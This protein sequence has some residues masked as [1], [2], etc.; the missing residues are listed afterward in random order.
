[1]LGVIH[2]SRMA[3]QVGRSDCELLATK[4]TILKSLRTGESWDAYDLES[5]LP[6]KEVFEENT[7]FGFLLRHYWIPA[8]NLTFRQSMVRITSA[9]ESTRSELLIERQMARCRSNE[10]TWREKVFA[11]LSPRTGASIWEST[12][13][14]ETFCSYDCYDQTYVE[15]EPIRFALPSNE[16]EKLMARQEAIARLPFL[17]PPGPVP[18]GFGWYSKAGTSHMNFCLESKEVVGETSVLAIKREGRVVVQLSLDGQIDYSTKSTQEEFSTAIV[19]RKGITLFA[20][21]RG[22]VLE[23]RFED[24][25]IETC[26]PSASLQEA[27]TRAVLRLV[28]STPTEDS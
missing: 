25:V 4:S 6:L 21:S 8:T 12:P 11:P 24:R 13:F 20:W 18:V 16:K 26:D 2:E 14:R 10:C 23:D 17:S 28:R 5:L 15:D 9:A 1:M 19:E 3:K 7:E 22:V 27:R